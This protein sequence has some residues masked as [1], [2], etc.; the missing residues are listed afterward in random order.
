MKKSSSFLAGIAVVL[1]VIATWGW[2]KGGNDEE[3]FLSAPGKVLFYK[4]PTCGCCGVHASYLQRN[5]A[6]DVQTINQADVTPVKNKYR[7]PLEL[8]SCHT[9]I[10]GGYFVEG[11]IPI[12]AIAKL[13]N[14]KPAIAGIAMPGMPSGSPGMPGAKTGP[15]VIYAVN[16]D[17]SYQE[18]MRI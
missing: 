14:E 13:V 9:A 4:S 2:A 18:F 8:R 10:I 17:G 15:F 6:L 3:V 5:G 12:E 1:L 11:H 7:V 16:N